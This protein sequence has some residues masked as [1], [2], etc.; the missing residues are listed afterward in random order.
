MPRKMRKFIQEPLRRPRREKPILP[1]WIFILF[2]SNSMVL[3]NHSTDGDAYYRQGKFS[4]AVEE[5]KKAIDAMEKAWALKKDDAYK[6]VLLALY[7]KTQQF[8][9]KKTLEGQ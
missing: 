9:K 5:Y 2:C 1:L 4:E 6:R 7:E 8:D 3:A